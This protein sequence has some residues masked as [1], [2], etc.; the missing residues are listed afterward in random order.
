MEIPFGQWQIRDWRDTD[1]VALVKYANN[2][3]IWLNVHDVFPHPY[4]LPDAKSWIQSAKTRPKTEFAI[5]SAEEAIGG[6]G[7]RLQEDIQ[8][9]SAEVGYWLGEPF[10]GRGIAT[11]AVKTLVGYA[12]S[13]FDLVRLHAFVFEWNFAS[14]RVLEKSGFHLEARIEKSVTKDGKTVDCFLYALIR[15]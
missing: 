8:R 10:W 6:I 9:R 13:N 15:Q 2:R 12:F 14:C 1:H 3:R 11:G 5:A 4:T 7:L